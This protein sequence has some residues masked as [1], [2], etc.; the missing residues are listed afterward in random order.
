MN[1]RLKLSD[2]YAANHIA[3]TGSGTFGFPIIAQRGKNQEL[4]FEIKCRGGNTRVSSQ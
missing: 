1:G 2:E 3:Q 4:F